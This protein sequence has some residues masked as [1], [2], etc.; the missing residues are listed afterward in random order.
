VGQTSAQSPPQL[1]SVRIVN[2][3]LPMLPPRL[4]ELV[5]AVMDGWQTARERQMILWSA[6]LSYHAFLAIFPALVA[7]VLLYGL[8]ADPEQILSQV[9]R[10]TDNLPPDAQALIVDQVQVLVNQ[11]EGLGAGLVVSLVVATVSASSGVTN[12]MTA[13]N[14]TY[15]VVQQRSYLK[16]RL[17]SFVAMLGA[18][19][20]MVFVLGLVAVLPAIAAFIDFGA[21]RWVIEVARW[22]TTAVVFAATLALIYRV[23]PERTPPSLRWVSLGAV[24]AT[25]V[26]LIA[27]A[28]FS[29]YVTN[30]DALTK[31]YGTLAGI[32]VMLLWLWILSVA[33][34]LGAQINVEAAERFG[35]SDE[36]EHQPEQV[37]EPEPAGSDH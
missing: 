7:G 27:S 13:I 1:L 2:R 14:A 5:A 21:P 28:G 34:L 11:P 18:V 6:G 26:G 17:M 36:G 22:L 12:L 23:F 24:I 31:T 16:R 8:F 3:L 35:R 10:A 33:V 37:V 4:R 9:T 25:L 29:I 19:V 30:F 15:G 32:V 20:F